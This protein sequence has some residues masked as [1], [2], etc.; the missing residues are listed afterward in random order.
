VCYP[1]DFY[2]PSLP[3]NAYFEAEVLANISI[4]P[5][6]PLRHII[7][8]LKPLTRQAENNKG[9]LEAQVERYMRMVKPSP[10]YPAIMEKVFIRPRK[11]K[12]KIKFHYSVS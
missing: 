8:Y 3:N 11:F 9:V 2:A 12:Y 7:V 10:F 4:T 1:K 5:D 6:P